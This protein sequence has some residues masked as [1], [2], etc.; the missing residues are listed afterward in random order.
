MHY[1][2]VLGAEAA[3]LIPTPSRFETGPSI[4]DFYAR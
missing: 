2:K 4:Q 3:Q 1:L